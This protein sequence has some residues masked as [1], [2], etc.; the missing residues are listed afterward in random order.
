MSRLH[1]SA[2]F[3]VAAIL[4]VGAAGGSHAAGG[5]EP[6]NDVAR[7]ITI[8]SGDL[9]VYGHHLTPPYELAIRDGVLAVNG[10]RIF[11]PLRPRQERD[12]EVA[13]STRQRHELRRRLFTL[14]AELERAGRTMAEITVQ[15]S[16]RL[17]A[18]RALV[19]SVT[20]G[21]DNAFWIWW[22]GELLPEQFL[23]RRARG[24]AA[25]R[26]RAGEERDL[27]RHAL[28]RDCL[29]IIAPSR[30]FIVPPD[31]PERMAQI[32]TE[33]ERA[34]EAAPDQELTPEQWSGRHLDAD[35]AR[36]FQRPLPLPTGE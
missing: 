29:V 7:S 4:A 16:E 12:I 22:C 30:Q 15:L 19:D 26:A 3:A 2:R 24:S 36:L 25:R 34:R 13:E 9:H 5:T 8:S 28:E 23:V 31:P 1:S 6:A 32:L 20:G 21:S 14:Q 17:Y 33:I 35:L 11:P 18:E 27:L 10:V